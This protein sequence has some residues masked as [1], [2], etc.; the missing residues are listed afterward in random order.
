MSR[1]RTFVSNGGKVY[2]ELIKSKKANI[3]FKKYH[4]IIKRHIKQN[5]GE[6]I[7]YTFPVVNTG[8]NSNTRKILNKIMYD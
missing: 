8:I 7:Y 3:K 5:V 2:E 1:L 6:Q 4:K